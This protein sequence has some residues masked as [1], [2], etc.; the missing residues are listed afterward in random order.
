MDLEK[1]GRFIT[2]LRNNKNLTQEQLGKM[3]N[4]SS[5]TVSKWERGICM[6]NNSIMID[7]CEILG[8][9]VK[10]LLL[11]ERIKKT[12]VS[13]EEK[14]KE[15]DQII[16]EGFNYCEK[17]TKNKILKISIIIFAILIS[18]IGVVLVLYYLTYFNQIKIYKIY[19]D[20]DNFTISGKIIFNP[21][22]RLIIIND[23][24]YNDVYVG[25]NKEIKAKAMELELISEDITIYKTGNLDYFKEAK[26]TQLN[27][28]LNKIKIDILQTNKE[29]DLK[30]KDLA[31]C[32]VKIKYIDKKNEMQL[33]EFKLNL[34]KVFSNDKI[35][36]N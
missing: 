34:E 29:T 8:I 18:I 10:E 22:N 12:E 20:E 31:N 23:I 3:I 6:P 4:A 19:S 9:E 16:V 25:T 32:V 2:E 17:K 5:Q 24:Q 35:F 26:E 7:L 30:E 28:Y 1:I 14:N 27:T 11:G 33:I 21:D 13:I 36:S 15:V